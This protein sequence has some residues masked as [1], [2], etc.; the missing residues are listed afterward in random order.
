[1]EIIHFG[2]I[3]RWRMRMYIYCRK[4]LKKKKKDDHNQPN[5]EIWT[6]HLN[7]T[8]SI[9]NGQTRLSINR[10]CGISGLRSFQWTSWRE[11]PKKIKSQ[12]AQNINF[13]LPW[14]YRKIPKVEKTRAKTMTHAK[15][16]YKIYPNIDSLQ[17]LNSFVLDALGQASIWIEKDKMAT[18]MFDMGLNY[19]LAT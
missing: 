15:L 3:M 11:N 4:L 2:K 9:F 19:L 7:G 5:Q 6:W 14:K 10:T 16:K 12:T 1:M 8:Q 18:V 13:T 17:C